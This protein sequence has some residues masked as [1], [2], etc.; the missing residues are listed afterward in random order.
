MNDVIDVD[1]DIDFVETEISNFRLIC[2]AEE[3][4]GCDEAVY[5]SG[6]DAFIFRAKRLTSDVVVRISKL[7]Q[8]VNAGWLRDERI[9]LVALMNATPQY[10]ARTFSEGLIL[11]TG[12]VVRMADVVDYHNNVYTYEVLEYIPGNPSETRQD[13]KSLKSLYSFARTLWRDGWAHGDFT[14]RNLRYNRAKNKW[15]LVDLK[16]VRHDGVSRRFPLSVDEFYCNRKRLEREFNYFGDASSLQGEILAF[17]A[18]VVFLK[19]RG[20]GPLTRSKSR[21][22]K[23]KSKFRTLWTTKRR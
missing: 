4:D 19:Q 22:R 7:P 21:A 20:C 3:L 15:V 14:L 10:F 11:P 9:R 16:K 6:M 23:S 12:E 18:W 5:G 13:V 17:P 8:V 2:V 1:D